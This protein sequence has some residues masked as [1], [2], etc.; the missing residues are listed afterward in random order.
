MA[1]KD[2][3]AHADIGQDTVFSDVCSYNFF[4][5]MESLYLH[6]GHRSVVSLD[7]EPEDEI[8][9][10]VADASL[11]FPKSDVVSL[12]KKENGQYA[13][14]VSFS[15]LHG[16]QSPLPGYYLDE[17]ALEV[18]Q[19]E[20]GL[21]GFLDLFAHRWTQFLYHIWRKYR[22]YV[23]FRNGGVDDFSRRMYALVGLESESLRDQ[24]AINHSKMLAYAGTL[25]SPGRSPEVICSLISHCFDLPDVSL[26]GWQLRQVDITPE[27]QNRL[28]IRTARTGKKF[29]EKSVLG[30][31]FTLGSRI[32]DRSGKFLLCIN[33]LSR[34]RL[35]SFLPN[36]L[37]FIPLTLFVAF[38]L[39]DQLAWDLRLG[40]A[41][42]QAGGM[43][44]GRAQNSLLGWTSFIGQPEPKPGVIINVRS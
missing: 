12:T 8:A 26:E 17:L 39:R 33:N 32:P 16:S 1:G 24:L 28:G 40:F 11:A 43:V 29:I 31:N 3:S 44:L 23:C 37:N 15:G 41:P 9:H 19:E 5:L 35:L 6:T 18:A 14:T 2:R 13:I 38:I 34:D 36:G 25:A 30:S 27:R 21:A 7:T 10:F 22:Y 42:D 20:E 4:A